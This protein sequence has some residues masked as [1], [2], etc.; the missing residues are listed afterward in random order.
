MVRDSVVITMKWITV[1]LSLLVCAAHAELIML[2]DSAT[3]RVWTN[4]LPSGWRVV[5]FGIRRND[6]LVEY[7]RS[8]HPE[9]TDFPAAVDTETKCVV[10]A[11]GTLQQARS[12]LRGI[13]DSRRPALKRLMAAVEATGKSNVVHALKDRWLAVANTNRTQAARLSAAADYMEINWRYI[14]AENER[15]ALG[16]QRLQEADEP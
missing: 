13:D 15:E 1:I 4:G 3:G 7:R 10:H 9:P 8:G 16:V 2:N 5:D 6:D 12:K 14:A 11:T